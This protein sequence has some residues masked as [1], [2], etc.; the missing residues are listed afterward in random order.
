[1][2]K[3][4]YKENL[5]NLAEIFKTIG[6]P[7]RLCIVCKLLSKNLNVTQ[8]QDCLEMP[9]STVSQ[10]LAILKSKGIIEG[11]RN[12][13]EVIYS[14]VNEDVKKIISSILNPDDLLKFNK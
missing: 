3:D 2:N 11:N 1:M 14:L 6:H 4:E 10:H 8:I 9:Q 5:K 12:G 13:V 7:T